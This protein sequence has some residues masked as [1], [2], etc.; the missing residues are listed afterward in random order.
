MKV[1]ALLLNWKRPENMKAVIDGIR[2]QSVPVEIILWNNNPDDKTDYKADIQINSS[3]NLICWP[4]WLM[5]AHAKG[6]YIFTNDDDL[7]LSDINVIQD[8]IDYLDKRDCMIGYTGVKVYKSYFNAKH[9]SQPKQKDIKVDIIKGRFMFLKKQSLSRVPII[10]YKIERVEDDILINHYHKGD[11]ILPA[12]LSGRF[13]NLNE[14][15]EAYS[16]QPGHK[17]SRDKI[18]K[19]LFL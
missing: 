18:T 16:L 2:S 9:Y 4:R 10:P 13:E 14:G 3:E 12:M 5:M 17:K 19:K 11:K 15:D 6:D 1:T 7:K 8:C